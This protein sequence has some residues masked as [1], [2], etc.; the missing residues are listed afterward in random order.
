MAEE[1]FITQEGRPETSRSEASFLVPEDIK[2]EHE[3]NEKLYELE[4]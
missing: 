1:A 3:L 2:E 4:D